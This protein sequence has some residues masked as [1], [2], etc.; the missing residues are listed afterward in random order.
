M[1][2]LKYIGLAMLIL[3]ACS[4]EKNAETT[5]RATL[6]TKEDRVVNLTKEQVA[7]IKIKTGHVEKLDVNNVIK[8]NGYL[9]V[10]PQNNAV[11]S[12][13]ITG[14]VRKINYLIGDNVKK[15]QV[16]AE[17]ESMEFIDMQQQYI[18][19]NAQME[20][21]KQEYERQKLLR[22]SN[23]V[24]KKTFLKAEVEYKTAVSIFEG[25]KSKLNLLGGNFEQLGQGKIEPHFVLRAPISGSVNKMNTMIGKHVDPSEEI[26]EIVN[27]EH[28]HLELSVFEQDVS[29]VK[30][31]QKVW[32]R[33]SDQ[34]GTIYEG[35]VFLVGKDL[36]VDKRSINVHVHIH[37]DE[38]QLPVG[39]Y[40]NASIVVE[41]N[42]SNTL[43][44]T[45]VVVQ[46]TD[47][48][49]FKMNE[50]SSDQVSFSKIPVHTGMESDGL[51][52]LTSLD[53]IST[54]DDI[55]IEGA[56]YLL[57]AFSKVD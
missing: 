5:N 55:V 38:S 9:D 28:V 57:N 41:E 2:T 22:D 3:S 50:Q 43:P 46:G 12:P 1:K 19:L 6:Q 27:T 16:M 20:F 56:F 7:A 25:L 11:V 8:A 53:G 48:F 10:P 44:V 42:P 32:F 15:G 13:M 45:A 36:S 34:P 33:V 35:E 30:K 37:G 39:M 51:I 4:K 26:F 24:S 29:K 40:V 49:V 14:Y 52:E 47:Q 18:E 21:L 31:G 17:L 23:A 54:S